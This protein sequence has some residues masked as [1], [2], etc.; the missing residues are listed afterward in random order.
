MV[1]KLLL[2]S[3]SPRRRQ[4]LAGL[5]IPMEVVRLKDIDETHP[6]SLSG[7]DIPLDRK[8]VV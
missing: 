2:A 6:A 1:E 5:D 7:G 8:S 3:N 4:L